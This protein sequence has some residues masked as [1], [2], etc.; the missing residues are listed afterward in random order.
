MYILRALPWF[1]GFRARVGCW[2]CAGLSNNNWFGKHCLARLQ[3]VD[4]CAFPGGMQI[5]CEVPDA[6]RQVGPGQPHDRE[7]GVF[8]HPAKHAGCVHEE[9]GDAVH[10]HYGLRG[11][12]ASRAGRCSPHEGRAGEGSGVGGRAGRAREVRREGPALGGRAREGQAGEERGEEGRAGQ[13]DQQTHNRRV[14]VG[15]YLYFGQALCTTVSDWLYAPMSGNQL[16]SLRGGCVRI[17]TK[18]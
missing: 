4:P 3:P 16:G 11:W 17:G 12:R 6:G 10:T 2:A 15:M 5:R 1:C 8:T 13:I 7:A 18:H 9:V 14:W